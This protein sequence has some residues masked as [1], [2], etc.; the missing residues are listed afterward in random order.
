MRR[1]PNMAPQP[2]HNI[3]T[4]TEND[5]DRAK[6][7]SNRSALSSPIDIRFN[8]PPALKKSRYSS[9]LGQHSIRLDD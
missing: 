6:A 9:V 7:T 4:R 3:N 1:M 2:Q 5:A 8:P